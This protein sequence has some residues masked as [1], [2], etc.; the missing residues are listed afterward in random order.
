MNWKIQNILR[1]IN[2]VFIMI[3]PYLLESYCICFMISLSLPFFMQ[4]NRERLMKMA[5]AVRTGG[6]GSVRRQV[7][8]SY[9]Q[10]N[11][12]LI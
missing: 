4:M 8:F 2:L 5:G 11:F 10:C 9:K 1:N 12:K 7:C 3:I 6:K